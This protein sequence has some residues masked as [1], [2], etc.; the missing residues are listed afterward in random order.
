MNKTDDQ[1]KSAIA[2]NESRAEWGAWAIVVG[3]VLEIVLALSVSFGFEKK[4]VENWGAVLADSL[5]ALGVYAEIH[6][7]RKASTA[8]AELRQRADVKVAEANER[9]SEANASAVASNERI[10]TLANETEL[11]K[12]ENL[13][14][15]SAFQPRRIAM[16]GRGGDNE[17]RAARFNAVKKYAGTLALIQ[18]VPDFEAQTLAAD[19]RHALVRHGNWRAEMTNGVPSELISE[20]VQITTLEEPLLNPDDSANTGRMLSEAARAGQA[21]TDLLW[22]DLGPPVGPLSGVQSWPMPAEFSAIIGDFV[23]PPG[24]VLILVGVRPVTLAFIGPP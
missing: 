8:S 14:L 5:I 11:L 13:R 20:G 23:I 24:T 3:L 18:A 6:F 15:Q 16:V 12:R 4:W 9:A 21:V 2:V 7:G 1:L 19:I 10:A 17:I 22:L